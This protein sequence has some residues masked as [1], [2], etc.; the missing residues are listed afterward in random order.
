MRPDRVGNPYQTGTIAT[1]PAAWCHLAQ[2]QGSSTPVRLHLHRHGAGR[3]GNA[4]V[5]SLEAPGT[6]AVSAGLAK[7]IPIRDNLRLR[8][9]STFTNVL[10]HTNYAPPPTNISN[11]GAF[12]VLT[13]AQTA[14]NAGNRTGQIALRLEF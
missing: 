12:G 3:I 2:G 14:E 6:I 5:G 9:E 11:P 13:G 8:F 7:V 1:N 4:G 10:N